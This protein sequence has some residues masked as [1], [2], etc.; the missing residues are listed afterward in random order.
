MITVDGEIVAVPVNVHSENWL[1]YRNRRGK[2]PPMEALED[3]TVF[4]NEAK[5]FS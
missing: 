5:K 1:W 3:W 4:L 2:N